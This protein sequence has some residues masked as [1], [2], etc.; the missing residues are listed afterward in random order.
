M[1]CRG[2]V[3][4]IAPPHEGRNLERIRRQPPGCSSYG[5]LVTASF[6][7]FGQAGLRG[8]AAGRPRHSGGY[9]RG[10]NAKGGVLCRQPSEM[11]AIVL[12]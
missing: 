5:I 4:R 8:E 7:R 9:I 2:F 6:L 12:F 3:S 1:R 10:F 11:A